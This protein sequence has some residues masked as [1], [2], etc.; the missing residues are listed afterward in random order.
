MKGPIDERDKKY[1]Q[2][3]ANLKR[4]NTNL[5]EKVKLLE[6]RLDFTQNENA[7]LAVEMQAVIQGVQHIVNIAMKIAERERVNTDMGLQEQPPK[8]EEV[9]QPKEGLYS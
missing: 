6:K 5:K 9:K 4:D 2:A 8:Q 3:V 7:K 1:A